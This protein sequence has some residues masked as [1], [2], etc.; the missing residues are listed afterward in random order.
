MTE[1]YVPIEALVE[2]FNNDPRSEKIKDKCAF[3]RLLFRGLTIGKKRT[4]RVWIMKVN[5][6]YNCCLSEMQ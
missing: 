1:S 3:W 6:K 2:V 4:I 5:K